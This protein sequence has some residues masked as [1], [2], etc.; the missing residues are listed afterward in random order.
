MKD[1]FAFVVLTWYRLVYSVSDI[2]LKASKLSDE[3]SL[4]QLLCGI[5]FR[6]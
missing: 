2:G 3:I 6:Q 5:I 4:T 1:I